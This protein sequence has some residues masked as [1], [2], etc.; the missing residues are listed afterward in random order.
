VFTLEG[1]RLSQVENAPKVDRRQIPS[2]HMGKNTPERK[3]CRRP[4]GESDAKST[5]NPKG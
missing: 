1:K 4:R 3:D 2:F 5:A